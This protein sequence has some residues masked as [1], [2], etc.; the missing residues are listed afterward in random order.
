MLTPTRR[1]ELSRDVT[2][3]NRVRGAMANFLSFTSTADRLR[4]R[5]AW[6]LLVGLGVALA[7]G[8]ENPN[9]MFHGVWES[10]D[11]ILGAPF[12]GAPTLALGHYGLEVTGVATFHEA[13]GR[14]QRIAACPCAFISHQGVDLDEGVVRFSTEL[15]LDTCGEGADT[16]DWELE[17]GTDPESGRRLLE[18]TV[19]PSDG[20]QPPSNARFERVS[21]YIS[22]S[23]RQCPPEDP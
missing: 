2:V 12:E 10:T 21:L 23:D 22:E 15:E 14:S 18:G 7:A 6:V 17:L 4:A 16:L 3:A 19:L 11:P 9:E 20:S 13:V 5:C 1:I 8:C